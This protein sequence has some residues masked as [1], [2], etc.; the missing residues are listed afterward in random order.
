MAVPDVVW[1]GF[2]RLCT[3]RRV[4]SVPA[5]LDDTLGFVRAFTAQPSYLHL[6]GL[7]DGIEPFLQTVSTSSASA[8]LATDAGRRRR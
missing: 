7:Q 8:N 5:G 4:F 2:V 1:V 6:G 3:D